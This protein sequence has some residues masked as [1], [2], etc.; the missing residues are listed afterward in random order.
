MSKTAKKIVRNPD[1]V[2]RNEIDDKEIIKS[3]A[4]GED[5]SQKGTVLLVI[6]DMIHEL[7][8]IGGKIWVLCD[9]TRKEEDIVNELLKIFDADESQLR[10]DVH[11]FI[12]KLIKDGWLQYV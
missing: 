2:W 1:I 7:N 8:F 5:I 9:S 10:F 12:S 3:I 4:Q 11:T 6:S